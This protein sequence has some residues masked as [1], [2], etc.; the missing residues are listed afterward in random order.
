MKY[1]SYTTKNN[2]NTKAVSLKD[3]RTIE[4]HEGT[5]KSAIKYSVMITYTDTNFESFHYLE[6]DEAKMVY[7]NL[8]KVLNEA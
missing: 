6:A 4:I 1:F 5:G 3:I 2:N 7:E 8:V